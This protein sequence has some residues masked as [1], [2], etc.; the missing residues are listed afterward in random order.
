MINRQTSAP[1]RGGDERGDRLTELGSLVLLQEMT[2][3]AD[4]GVV[5]TGGPGNPS[6]EDHIGAG[7]RR[8]PRRWPVP[9]SPALGA[10]RRAC[11]HV[12]RDRARENLPWIDR[13]ALAGRRLLL[14]PR[15]GRSGLRRGP[16]RVL[17]LEPMARD[18]RLTAGISRTIGSPTRLNV[19]QH[20]AVGALR[21]R[22][23]L[24]AQ[25]IWTAVL[26][27]HSCLHVARLPDVIGCG[28]CTA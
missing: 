18:T 9:G 28:G 13:N 6:A 5:R 15:S 16:G 21:V 1:R 2:S 3:A 17:T 11:G 22:Y 4:R 14:R 7:G 10:V 26:A 24:V 8:R 19:D 12:R 27:D 23:V 20:A 25:N